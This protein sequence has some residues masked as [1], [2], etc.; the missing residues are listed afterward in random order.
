MIAN[1]VVLILV[2]AI[3]TILAINLA[4]PVLAA[5]SSGAQGISKAREASGN[6]RSCPGLNEGASHVGAIASKCPLSP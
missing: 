6:A 2:A 3:A 5:S 1:A 4:I